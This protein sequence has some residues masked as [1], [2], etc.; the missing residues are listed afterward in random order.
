MLPPFHPED[1]GNIVS[2][3]VVTCHNTTQ[4]HKPVDLHVKLLVV[5][6]V[7]NLFQFREVVVRS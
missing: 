5:S 1:G 2:S 3:T 6:S 7:P 4:R